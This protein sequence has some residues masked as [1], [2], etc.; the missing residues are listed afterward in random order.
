MKI[1]VNTKHIKA[2][3]VGD[4]EHCPIARAV[5]EAVNKSCLKSLMK[6]RAISV[7]D[8]EITVGSLTMRATTQISRFVEKFDNEEKVKPFTFTLKFD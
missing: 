3:I 8:E 5:R 1:N 2:G 6:D 7:D 4:D